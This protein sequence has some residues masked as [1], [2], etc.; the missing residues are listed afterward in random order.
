MID[1]GEN[2]P[3]QQRCQR[4]PA[5]DPTVGR[6]PDPTHNVSHGLCQCDRST[7]R[8]ELTASLRAKGRVRLSI[9]IPVRCAR[10]LC[11]PR[12]QHRKHDRRRADRGPSQTRVSYIRQA[13]CNALTDAVD[14]RC[15]EF[16]ARGHCVI[17]ELNGSSGRDRM[18]VVSP[19]TT[20][21][22][23]ESCV[24]PYWSGGLQAPARNRQGRHVARELRL[25]WE[26]VIP[27]QS[28]QLD[29]RI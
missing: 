9:A 19:A 11:T 3:D 1:C 25:R 28:R 21:I 10:G 17:E 18:A 6:C 7:P 8:R 13:S 26:T 12:R 16:K 15:L 4:R 2:A 29:T 24:C 20:G 5:P 23:V 22:L 27:G 14:R